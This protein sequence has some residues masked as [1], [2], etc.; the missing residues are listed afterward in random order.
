MFFE[1]SCLF[2]AFDINII[3]LV[4]GMR[5]IGQYFKMFS[6]VFGEGLIN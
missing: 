1:I 4:V 2:F 6:F 3:K 5:E